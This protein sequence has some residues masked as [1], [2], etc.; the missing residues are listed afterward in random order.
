MFDEAAEFFLADVMVGAFAG[1]EIL[2]GLVFYLEAL[3][4]DDL[5]VKFAGVPNLALLQFHGRKSN[6]NL[7]GWGAFFKWGGRI[8]CKMPVF[9]WLHMGFENSCRLSLIFGRNGARL[10]SLLD[11][12]SLSRHGKSS[13]E[14]SSVMILNP[15]F[16]NSLVKE[17]VSLGQLNIT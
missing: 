10:R 17:T 4:M 5:E 12:L 7:R 8:D 9:K 15:K 2:E 3:E 6:W 11:S 13:G 16:G 1:G 14:L